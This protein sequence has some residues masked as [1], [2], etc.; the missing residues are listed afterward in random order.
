MQMDLEER[1]NND[2]EHEID[3][4]RLLRNTWQAFKQI[5]LLTLVAAVLFAAA[6]VFVQKKQYTPSYKAYCTMAVHVVNKA[7]LSDANSLYAV[8]YDQDL[9]EQLDATFSYLVNSDF[10]EDDI[11][12]YLGTDTIGGTMKSK[13][14]EGSNL[15]TLTTYSSSPEKAGA[16]LEALMAVYYDA[17]RYVM[18]D[19]KNEIIEGPVVSQS[20]SNAPNYTKSAALGVVI[21]LALGLAVAF[22]HALLKHTVFTPADLEEHLNAP[23]LGVVPMMRS[24]RLQPDNLKEASTT[25]EQGMFRESIRGIARKLES[26][27]DKQGAKVLLV[28]STVPG[29]GKSTLSQSLAASFAHWGRRVVLVDGDLRKPS[30]HQ[31]YGYRRESFPL[32]EVLLGRADVESV[33]R[34]QQDGKLTLVLNSRGIAAPTSYVDSPAM[35]A[36]VQQLTAQADLVIIDTP[37]CNFLSDVSLYGQYA[38]GILYVVQQDRVTVAHVAETV[39]NLCSTENKLFGYAINGARET[40]EGY[41]KYGYGQYSYGKYGSY[42]RYGG[43]SKYHHYEQ[44]NNNHSGVSER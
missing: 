13:S 12:E 2:D 31:H 19:M 43:Y 29:E 27:M 24:G 32:E 26:A 20:P 17:A 5:W 34:Y 23:C 3:L 41:G 22:L 9:A 4:V 16:L 8:Y 25:R 44:Y 14:I 10:F 37:P 33:L 7:T 1:K 30:L 39:E 6:M 38:D 21:G 36:L 15:I 40:Q 18:G 28:T 35:K 42:G 11:K